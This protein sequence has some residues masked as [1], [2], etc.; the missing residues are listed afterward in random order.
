PEV[1]PIGSLRTRLLLAAGDLD[2]ARRAARRR[3]ATESS[4]LTEFD[5]ITRVRVLLADGGDAL[6]LIDALLAAAE[7]GGRRGSVVELLVLRAL[8][9][10]RAGRDGDALDALREAVTRA[11]PEGFV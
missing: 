6:D 2:E 7:D 4:Y 9:L 11:E 1:R 8:A 5:D 3:A 10:A